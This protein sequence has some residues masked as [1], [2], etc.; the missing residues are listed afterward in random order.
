MLDR[1]RATYATVKSHSQFTDSPGDRLK[2]LVLGL[3]SDPTLP[4]IVLGFLIGALVNYVA[5]HGPAAVVAWSILAYA[6][7]ILLYVV[8]DEVRTALEA[9]SKELDRDDESGKE[10][11]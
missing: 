11:Q 9:A 8:G 4:N 5:G 2:T 1:L 6:L 10:F 3:V 7:S